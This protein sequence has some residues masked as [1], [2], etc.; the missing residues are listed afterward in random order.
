[1]KMVT[2][3]PTTT[4]CH[5]PPKHILFQREIEREKIPKKIRAVKSEEKKDLLK[6]LQKTKNENL[7]T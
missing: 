3:L 2:C 6:I 4:T 7:C 1:M 5:F